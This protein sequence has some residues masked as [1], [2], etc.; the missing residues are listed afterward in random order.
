MS[1]R[2]LVRCRTLELTTTGPG[3]TPAAT[4]AFFTVQTMQPREGAVQTQ[5][6][7]YLAIWRHQPDGS[8]RCHR[9]VFNNA[10]RP[11]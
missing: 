5:Q 3:E 7:R 1:D 4:A 11:I 6:S 9:F 2:A 10:P 8:W